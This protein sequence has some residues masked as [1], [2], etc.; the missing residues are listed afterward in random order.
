[1]T[2]SGGSSAKTGLLHTHLQVISIA[3]RLNITIFHCDSFVTLLQLI[4]DNRLV[5]LSKSEFS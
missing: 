5:P 2:I 4:W 1:M 3:C